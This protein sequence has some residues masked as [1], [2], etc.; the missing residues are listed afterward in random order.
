MNAVSQKMNPA[1]AHEIIEALETRG[2]RVYLLDD[3]RIALRGAEA[4]VELR[5]ALM[6]HGAAARV[7]L[8]ERREAK[9]SATSSAHLRAPIAK[10]E[11]SA[12]VC[13]EHL[14]YRDNP[15]RRCKRPWK[16]HYPLARWA[17]LRA[18]GRP[19][20]VLAPRVKQQKAP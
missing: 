11:A 3:D 19:P 1:T 14:G 9:E 10:P 6:R 4:P 18:P 12:A 16:A 15:C 7:I 20:R 17:P 13:G 8:E 2:V 5:R